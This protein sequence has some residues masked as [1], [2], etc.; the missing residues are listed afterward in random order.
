MIV[1]WIRRVLGQPQKPVEKT[2][3]YG[4]QVYPFDEGSQRFS[5]RATSL[6]E[7]DNLAQQKFAN[8]VKEERTIMRT[9]FLVST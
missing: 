1:K 3:V 4:Y 6:E 7:A 8:L 2:F 5:V 9:F